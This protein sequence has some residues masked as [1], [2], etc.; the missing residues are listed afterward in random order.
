MKVRIGDR[1]YEIPGSCPVEAP[2]KK[3]LLR[4]LRDHGP[5]SLLTST[6][7]SKFAGCIEGIVEQEGVEIVPEESSEEHPGPAGDTDDSIDSK[8]SC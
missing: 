4:H 3:E 2:T 8:T 7:L 6:R 5:E 1:V